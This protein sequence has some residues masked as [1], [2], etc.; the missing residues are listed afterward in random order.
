MKIGSGVKMK[1]NRSKH[2][3]KHK[4]LSLLFLPIPKKFLFASFRA[5]TIFSG[6]KVKIIFSIS[7]L[8]PRTLSYEIPLLNT[9]PSSQSL[10]YA[11]SSFLLLVSGM[12][13]H[14]F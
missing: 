1:T 12:K 3:I 9:K 10:E 6:K 14:S 5:K 2:F 11:S 4:N 13:V 8:K 7:A